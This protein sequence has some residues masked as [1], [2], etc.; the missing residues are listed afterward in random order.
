MKRVIDKLKSMWGKK[1]HVKRGFLLLGT[2]EVLTSNHLLE[3]VVEL[4]AEIV[5]GTDATILEEVVDVYIV[6]ANLIAKLDLSEALIEK[7]SIEKLDRVFVDKAE[8][9]ST[10]P[11]Y[12]RHNRS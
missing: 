9:Q 11:G 1:Y 6:F 7:L 2:D 8:V 4:Q 10:N 5:Y 3:E 12:T